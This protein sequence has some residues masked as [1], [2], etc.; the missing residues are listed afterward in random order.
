MDLPQLELN[1]Q[2]FKHKPQLI[3][4]KNSELITGITSTENN[5]FQKERPSWNDQEFLCLWNKEINESV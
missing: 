1:L 2:P 3:L 5:T 4:N